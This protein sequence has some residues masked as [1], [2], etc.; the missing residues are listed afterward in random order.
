MLTRMDLADE[1]QLTLLLKTSQDQVQ[2]QL[3][4][5]TMIDK[6]KSA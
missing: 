2:E 1:D 3:E 6:E 4:A 5:Y